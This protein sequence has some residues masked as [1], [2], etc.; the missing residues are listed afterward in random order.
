MS[1][2]GPV[3]RS[4]GAYSRMEGTSWPSWSLCWQPGDSGGRYELPALAGV[5][6]EG[7]YY[8]DY[9]GV[10]HVKCQYDS[11]KVVVYI[12]NE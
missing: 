3:T 11:R 2:H 5:K 9:G 8:I 10:Y 7:L 6:T 1:P 4:S 12:E